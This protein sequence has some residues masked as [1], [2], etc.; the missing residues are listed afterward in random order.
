MEIT[1]VQAPPAAASLVI[2]AF[3]S[4]DAAHLAHLQSQ[5]YAEHVALNV[6][7]DKIIDLVDAYVESYQGRYGIIRQYPTGVLS[8]LPDATA[9]TATT[10]LF[11]L[12]EWIEANKAKL[13]ASSELQIVEDMLIL[14]NTTIY[15]LT[16][17]K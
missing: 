7:Y 8:Q 1:L 6:Y 17:L 2:A 13:G 16:N 15:K 10:M 5:S 3:E 9:M 4:R 11:S 14:I 12:G